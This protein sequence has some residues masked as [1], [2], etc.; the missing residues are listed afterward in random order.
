MYIKK[1]KIRKIITLAFQEKKSKKSKKSIL[2]KI[3]DI[4]ELPLLLR[5]HY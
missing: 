5:R 4:L 1:S 2:T 3:R